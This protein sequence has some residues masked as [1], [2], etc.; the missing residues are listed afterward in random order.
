MLGAA[1]DVVGADAGRAGATP[2]PPA[3]AAGAC[4][5]A[6][7]GRD[8]GSAGACNGRDGDGDGPPAKAGLG[9]ADGA[10]VGPCGRGPGGR[11]GSPPPRTGEV[12]PVAGEGAVMP[13]LATGLAGAAAA[14]PRVSFP[15]PG[16]VIMDLIR[17]TMA[18]SRLAKALT[19]T[20]RPSF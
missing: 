14:G 3:G 9:P 15:A 8:V 12:I 5:G 2:G 18:G 4:E 6:G 10:D 7:A 11:G 13:P 16:C 19:L 17:S 1:V 20:S